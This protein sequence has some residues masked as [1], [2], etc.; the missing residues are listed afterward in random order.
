MAIR[1]KGLGNINGEGCSEV[2]CPSAVSNMG[3]SRT[4]TQ[5]AGRRFNHIY[6]CSALS[7]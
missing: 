1:S 3:E 6:K 5:S 4:G 2:V 7:H